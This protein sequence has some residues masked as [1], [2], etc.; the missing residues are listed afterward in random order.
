MSK[1]ERMCAE[2]R[3]NKRLI[4]ELQAMNDSLKA[5]IIA[6]MGDSDQYTEGA[7]K[8]SNKLVHSTRFD[9]SGFKSDFPEIYARY[10]KITEYRRF[11][12]L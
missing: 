6:C 8:V 7:C 9:S 11:S 1:F 10:S 4:D 12:V 3:E 5:D 2:Y